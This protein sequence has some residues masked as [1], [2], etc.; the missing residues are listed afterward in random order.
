MLPAPVETRNSI[1]SSIRV[2]TQSKK[3]SFFLKMFSQ[4]LEK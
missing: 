1:T 2:N 3:F 4:L